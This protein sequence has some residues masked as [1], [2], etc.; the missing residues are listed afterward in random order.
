[1][2]RED[3]AGCGLGSLTANPPSYKPT[4]GR[5]YQ[6][7]KREQVVTRGRSWSGGNE[8]KRAAGVTEGDDG[9]GMV[10]RGEDK[11][12][13]TQR[14]QPHQLGP[15]AAGSIQG[16]PLSRRKGKN[17]SPAVVRPRVHDVR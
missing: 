1:M 17:V 16:R 3:G 4:V 14:W 15:E 13:F 11:V 7:G 5:R 9:Q 8:G 6:S 2:M 12:D 10:S